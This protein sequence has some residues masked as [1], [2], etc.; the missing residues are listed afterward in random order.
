MLLPSPWLGQE[1]PQK[2]VD[3]SGHLLNRREHARR[4]ACGKRK[5]RRVTSYFCREPQVPAFLGA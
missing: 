4:S 1:P 3:S 2:D 5:R